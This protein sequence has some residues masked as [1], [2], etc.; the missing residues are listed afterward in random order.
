M[1]CSFEERIAGIKGYDYYPIQ[2]KFERRMRLF[3]ESD[4]K[5]IIN[6]GGMGLG[7]TI[8]TA[9][10]I[11]NHLKNYDLVY[12][13]TPTSPLKYTWCEEL[14][15]CD[16]KNRVSLWPSKN[17]V[18]VFRQIFKQKKFN[19]DLCNDDCVFRRDLNASEEFNT[20]CNNLSQEYLNMLPHATPKEYYGK[21]L[22]QI[23]KTNDQILNEVK[24]FTEPKR[25]IKMT[26]RT[27]YKKACGIS[28]L[29]SPSRN[30]LKNEFNNLQKII[31]GDYFGVFNNE[32]FEN[33]TSRSPQ[34]GDS[35]LIIDEGHL[36]S[37]R[38][39]SYNSRAI[40]L[41]RDVAKLRMEIEKN[42]QKIGNKDDISSLMIFISI[43]EYY[44][45]GKLNSE[46]YDKDFIK[47]NYEN[48]VKIFSNENQNGRK[49]LDNIITILIQLDK[50]M[51]N[52][53]EE[54]SKRS[55]CNK[56]KEYLI[57]L[58]DN[59]DDLDYYST[60]RK[61]LYFKQQDIQ[62][63]IDCINP[64]KTLQEIFNRWK[65]II[66]ISGTII[67][68]NK[69]LLDLGLSNKPEE[70]IFHEN[71]K[72]F[73]IEKNTFIY[74]YGNFGGKLRTQTYKQNSNKLSKI[75]RELKGKSILFIQSK[76]NAKAIRDSI[77]LSDYK[78]ID[79]CTHQNEDNE[80][81]AEE[82]DTLK[83]EFSRNKSE[84]VI[85]IMNIRGRVEGHNFVDEVGNFQLNNVIVYGFPLDSPSD[86]LIATYKRYHAMGFSKD[87]SKIYTWLET[88]ISK[89]HQAVYRSKR[90]ETSNPV[91][92][93]WGERFSSSY[94]GLTLS[95][96]KDQWYKL[97]GEKNNIFNNLPDEM[98]N[99]EGNY[100]QLLNFIK[101]VNNER[102][103]KKKNN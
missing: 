99:K 69:Y 65:K 20:S 40:Y 96:D 50:N 61:M 77:N 78:I 3:M 5:I 23:G 46:E 91:I 85:G 39:K 31:I 32:M 25:K 66:I 2:G 58:R 94:N 73:G 15:K 68:K 33:V 41:N 11:G 76:K 29:Y 92:I 6:Q 95:K 30:C 8:S 74:P 72:R 82:F 51:L 24:A 26:L 52:N 60:S 10:I 79:F 98:K 100:S 67:Y 53:N 44:Y 56:I 48:W 12:I 16:L 97:L 81:D 57:G 45:F 43:L 89:I 88:P 86:L 101:E 21:K 63:K 83:N 71:I 7:K 14:Y 62:M 70:Y 54:V 19:T 42:I 4:K 75:L 90:N 13:A 64:S 9:H 49:F 34:A 84:K 103:Y 17:S 22:K 37:L 35:L 80:I 18:C 102:T 87:D 27:D 28:C 55:S 59:G 1:K 47:I 93:L 38:S 36:L